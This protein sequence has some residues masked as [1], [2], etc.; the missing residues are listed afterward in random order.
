[1][2]RPPTH[3]EAVALAWSEGFAARDLHA[4]MALYEPGAIWVSDT[5]AVV[6][7]T[8]GIRE[9]MEQFLAL[10]ATYDGQAPQTMQ[11]GDLAL[12]CSEWTVRGTPGGAPLELVGRTADIV[13]RQPDG[14]WRYVI[15]APYG[16]SAPTTS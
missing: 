4:I 3:P 1:M 2:T 5:G 6:T 13:R 10:D 11:S 12:L 9:V 15:D 7:G 8:D 14:T 16:G